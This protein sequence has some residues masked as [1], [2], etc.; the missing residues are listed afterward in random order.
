[1]LAIV[2]LVT[3]ILGV[4]FCL[5]S[6]LPIAAIVTGVLGRNQIRESNGLEQGDGM[7]L[8]GLILGAVSLVVAVGWW[9]LIAVS[10]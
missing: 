10:P 6:V 1:M 3:G 7:A 8:A 9:I 5:C 4:P 2:S